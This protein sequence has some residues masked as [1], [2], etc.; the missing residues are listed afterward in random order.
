MR[1]IENSSRYDISEQFPTTVSMGNFWD[2][3]YCGEIDFTP[4]N[5]GE[6]QLFSENGDITFESEQ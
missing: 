5:V 4:E 3:E 2:R 1:A 6:G